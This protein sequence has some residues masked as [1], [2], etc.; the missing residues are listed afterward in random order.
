MFGSIDFKKKRIFFLFSSPSIYLAM[1]S[2]CSSEICGSG[3]DEIVADDQ[4]PPK[5]SPKEG[6]QGYPSAAANQQWNGPPVANKEGQRNSFVGSQP[7]PTTQEEIMRNAAP[8][9]QLAEANGNNASHQSRASSGK[10][11]TYLGEVA[12]SYSSNYFEREIA[13]LAALPA[14]GP[15]DQLVHKS[16]SF[17]SGAKYS[18]QWRGNKRHGAGTQKWPDGATYQ[19]DW[20]ENQA[21]GV[22]IFTHLDGD[23]YIGEWNENIADGKGVYHHQSKSTYQGQFNQDL[24]EGFG[25]EVWQEGS[26]F[27]GRFH[28]GK[29]HGCG[30]YK[31]PDGS[32]YVGEWQNNKIDGY[33]TYVGQ[34]GREYRGQWLDSVMHGW[35]VYTWPDGR[36]YEGHY[37]NDKKEGFGTFEW[38][39]GRKYEG[40]WYQGKQHGE[41]RLC[42]KNGVWRYAEWKDGKRVRWLEEGGR[43]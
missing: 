6:N 13:E 25:V 28:S 40:E 20:K 18:G 35:G 29:K 27:E 36:R 7:K 9:P 15:P 32:L 1:G 24:Q 17:E 5:G 41:G 23:V 11:N 22:G 21:S 33:G 2:V 42:L 38:Q 10:E 8:A 12:S 39:D 3:K 30:I 34:D 26:E 31:W 16:Y 14:W 19:G 37:V 4:S 43:K